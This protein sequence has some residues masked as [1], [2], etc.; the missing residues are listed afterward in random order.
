[1]LVEDGGVTT[2]GPFS[3][4]F[5]LAMH[6]IR[7]AATPK[8]ARA[9][10]R[11]ALLSQR[12]SQAAWVDTSMAAFHVSGRTMLRRLKVETRQT[13]LGYLQGE[14]INL[15]KRLL[16]AGQLSVAQITEKVGYLD[17]ATFSALFKR[18]AGRS[19]APCRRLQHTRAAA[20]VISS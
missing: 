7:Q 10:A 1:M 9:V 14:R 13:P 8:E 11:M 16:E 4:T 18:L 3:A 5:D 6:L 15:A 19:P 20:A 12:G 17:V 2:A